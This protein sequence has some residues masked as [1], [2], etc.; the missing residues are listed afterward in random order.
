V[1]AQIA[2]ESGAKF[3]PVGEVMRLK[4]GGL[5]WGGVPCSSWVFLN[6]G[7]SGRSRDKPLGNDW[8]ASVRS[9]NLIVTRFVLLCLLAVARGAVWL[10]E[11]PMSSLM[12]HHPRLQE[13]QRLG[14]ALG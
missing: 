4:I 14:C 13:V 11:Q 3:H 8:Q 1:C 6:R 5:L 9:S 7:T 10:A 12:L 2:P